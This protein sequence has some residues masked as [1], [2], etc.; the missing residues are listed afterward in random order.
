MKILFTICGRAGSKGFKNKNL[1]KLAGKPLA[2]YALSLIK[3]YQRRHP[4]N[5]C[6]ISLNTDSNELIE[7]M[8][9]LDPSVKVVKRKPELATDTVGKIEVIRDSFFNLESSE[10]PFDLIVDLDLTSPIRE[11]SNLEE[12]I[13]AHLND[14]TKDVYFSVVPARRNPYF[15]M[16]KQI[17]EKVT[18]VNESDFT[19]RQQAPKVFEMNASMYSFKPDFLKEHNYIFDGECGIVQ[20]KDYLIL[21]IDSEEDFEWLEFLFPKFLEDS[22]ELKE[23]YEF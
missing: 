11:I 15:N 21:D 9:H 18:I 22:A 3:I 4:E 17:D 20:M 16:V 8:V 5:E 10:E 13:T 1:K 7:L 12:L 14:L 19:S 6:V 2:Q 23:I